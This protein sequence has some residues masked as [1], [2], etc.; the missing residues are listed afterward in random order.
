MCLLCGVVSRRL[1]DDDRHPLSATHTAHN[2]PRLV[3]DGDGLANSHC[4]DIVL[5]LQLHCTAGGREVVQ[6]E[7]WVRCGT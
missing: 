3:D 5:F 2:L 7:C 1:I 4:G 6:P